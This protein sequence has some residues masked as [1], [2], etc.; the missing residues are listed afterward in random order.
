MRKWLPT[1]DMEAA[2][3]KTYSLKTFTPAPGYV[4]SIVYHCLNGHMPLA[5][6]PLL[7]LHSGHAV[8]FAGYPAAVRRRR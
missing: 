4:R 2:A 5:N 6:H 1:N 7:A 3:K 8:D